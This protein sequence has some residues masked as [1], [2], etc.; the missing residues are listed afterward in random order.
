MSES[1]FK[2]PLNGACDGA[3]V[4]NQ[5]SIDFH[6]GDFED[7]DDLQPSGGIVNVADVFHTHDSI[8]RRF[9]CGKSFEVLYVKSV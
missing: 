9:A 8:S 6:F 4:N 3:E 5:L 7:L 2:N 1:V